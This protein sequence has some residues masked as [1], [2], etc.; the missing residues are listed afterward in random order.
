MTV[1]SEIST[2]SYAGNGS[3]TA[4]TVPFYFINDDDLDVYL[5][6]DEGAPALKTLTTHYTLSGS[7]DPTGGTLTM[8][9]APASGETL[10]IVRNPA[11]VQDIDYVENDPFP[12]DTHETGLDL[13]TMIAQKL[14]QR[15]GRSLR[16]A[17]GDPNSDASF[18]LPAKADRLGKYLYF[19]A[20]NGVPEMAEAVT[21]GT[22]L[23]QSIIA[24]YL[25]PRTTAEIAASVTPTAYYYPPG[26]VRRYGTNTTPGTTDCTTMIANA[27]LVSAT[28]RTIFQPETYMTDKMTP[29]SGAS[30]YM[31]PGCS[32][33]DR[34]NLGTNER[35]LNLTNDNIHIV[36]WGATLQG[37][38]ASYGT[39]SAQRHGVFMYGCQNVY[40]EGLKS[41]AF[42]GDS[43]YVGG[44]VGD[45]ATN[46]MIFRC[47]GTNSTR[48]GLSIVSANGW[49]DIDCEFSG[50]GGATAGPCAGIDVEPNATTDV[51]IDVKSI[52]PKLKDCTGFGWQVFLATWNSTSNYI[53]YECI[54]PVES[55]CGTAT[56]SGSTRGAYEFNRV[57]STTPCRG[58]ISLI[59]PRSEDTENAGIRIVDWD[60]NGPQIVIVQ[61]VVLNPNQANAATSS[62]Q[63]GI[64]LYNST[65]YTTTPGNVR[66]IEPL[67]RDDDGFLNSNSLAPIRIDGA[68]DDVEITD[69]ETAYAGANP[70]SITS[71]A[72]GVRISSRRQRNVTQ[73]S[74]TLTMTD[75]RYIGRVIDN[76]GASGNVVIEL[77]A[78]VAAMAGWRIGFEIKAAQQLRID[79]NGTDLIRG[80]TAG[81][82]MVSSTIGDSATIE[83]DGAG[84]WKIVARYGTWSF[85]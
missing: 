43:F 28:H 35:F 15:M 21:A 12:A 73:A 42:D 45:P 49:R 71:T 79:P 62:S 54:D 66:I 4:F 65:S 37:V 30:I 68:W 34:G 77:P 61:P 67:V 52:R 53:D 39:P 22:T 41:D 17:D 80:G 84:T 82:Y 16:V 13:L 14:S 83:C 11:I 20:V 72:K 7:G 10:K 33:K 31:P 18:E 69:V 2:I 29:P 64:V 24:G 70:W 60:T 9:T 74:G 19:D 57:P 48:Q 50:I 25:W 59:R 63:S 6:D 76:S 47:R 38:K 40:I 36:G 1:A 5:I 85:V 32:I 75:G 44:G 58:R 46:C 26:D 55:G 3:T 23:S 81:Q 78:A 27:L 51:L 56:I 8:L